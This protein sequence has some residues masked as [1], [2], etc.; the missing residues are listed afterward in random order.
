MEKEFCTFKACELS[1]E[2]MIVVEALIK[3]P[4]YW[5]ILNWCFALTFSEPS[6]TSKTELFAEIFNSF[7]PLFIFTVN[8]FHRNLHL[9]CLNG[10]EYTFVLWQQNT[11]KLDMGK[12]SYNTH[13]KPISM[14]FI[15]PRCH[16]VYCFF[17]GPEAAT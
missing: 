6:Q 1:K 14:S 10:S 15:K 17:S 9:R 16:F 13:H 11:A 4:P 8:Y 2:F 3:P 7:K 5:I 12:D